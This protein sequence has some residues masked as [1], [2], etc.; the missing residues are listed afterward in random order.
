MSASVLK[1]H[2]IED[3]VN[4][5][6]GSPVSF[7]NGQKVTMKLITKFAAFV[8]EEN[9]YVQKQ[10]PYIFRINPFLFCKLN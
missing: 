8:C 10:S 3:H 6:S 2:N 9:V 4:S 7:V 1:L 5:F